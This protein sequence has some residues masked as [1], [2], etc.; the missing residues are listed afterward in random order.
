MSLLFRQDNQLLSRVLKDQVG[1]G[2][3]GVEQ[4]EGEL[5]RD[6][7]AVKLLS[8]LQ[9]VDERVHLHLSVSRRG[10]DGVRLDLA[11][12]ASLVI[13]SRS[14]GSVTT[15]QLI[16]RRQLVSGPPFFP[17]S[18]AVFSDCRV[19]DKCN[20]ATSF[21]ETPESSGVTVIILHVVPVAVASSSAV[22][23]VT[24]MAVLPV[25]VLFAFLEVSRLRAR[26]TGLAE[27][28]G[29]RP[30]SIAAVI[31]D[32]FIADQPGKWDDPTCSMAN[33]LKDKKNC[34]YKKKPGE[35]LKKNVT[36]ILF[37]LKVLQVN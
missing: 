16:I 14:S 20:V 29:R 13:S 33:C 17:L 31:A 34:D 2:R 22:A 12:V 11:Q 7:L 15:E 19:L 18:V 10:H 6:L 9:K 25:I 36:I 5:I 23:E 32:A 30:L 35:Q 21:D 8:V 24:E 37:I 4:R 1:V 28:L 3:F 26:S 27:V